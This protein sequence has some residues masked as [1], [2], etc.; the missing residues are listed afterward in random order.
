MFVRIAAAIVTLLKQPGKDDLSGFAPLAEPL[1][2]SRPF[3]ETL[4][5]PSSSH[6]ATK[7]IS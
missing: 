7:V 3:G 5:R 1:A 6:I 2:D 4:R